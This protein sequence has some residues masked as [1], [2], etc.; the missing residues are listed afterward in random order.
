MFRYEL[1][2]EEEAR[3]L[4][5]FGDSDW[6]GCK[7]S[8]R[9]ASGGVATLGGAFVKGWSNRQ[10]TVATSSAEAEFYASMKATVETLGLEPLM[11][12]LGWAVSD[13]EV[14][15]DFNAARVMASRRGLGRDRHIDVERLWLQEVVE[16]RGI[17]LGRADGKKNLGDP[18]TKL[19]AHDEMMNLLRMAGIA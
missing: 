10:A 13:K 1:F 19:Q 16:T 9:S 11:A 17:H 12:D 3:R 6:A 8:R 5:T 18:F 4:T 2:G 7:A 15:T 14:L